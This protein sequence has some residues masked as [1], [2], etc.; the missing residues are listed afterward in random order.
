MKI[1]NQ[2]LKKWVT[3]VLEG[4]DPSYSLVYSTDEWQEIARVAQK[5]IQLA[6][7]RNNTK[8]LENNIKRKE[9]KE[10]E[11]NRKKLIRDLLRR[12][13]TN[14]LLLDHYADTCNSDKEKLELKQTAL[15][16]TSPQDLELL[17]SLRNEIKELKRSLKSDSKLISGHV[18]K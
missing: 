7:I 2:I 12:M 10:N 15:Q 8:D 9:Y 16:H 6:C 4:K 5:S 3:S 1:S 17:T 14:P 18:K 11:N 13:P